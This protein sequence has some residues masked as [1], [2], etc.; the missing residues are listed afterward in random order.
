MTN[1][2]TRIINYAVNVSLSYA[3]TNLIRCVFQGTAM[4]IPQAR[5]LTTTAMRINK[6][7]TDAGAYM[8][9]L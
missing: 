1:V 5:H 4:L 6:F 7:Q 9:S 2:R 3:S 8:P